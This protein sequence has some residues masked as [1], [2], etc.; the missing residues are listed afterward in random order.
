MSEQT[1]N[2]SMSGEQTLPS[3]VRRGSRYL[4]SGRELAAAL[5]EVAD[6]LDGLGVVRLCEVALM[7]SLQAVPWEDPADRY[8]TVTALASRFGTEPGARVD[9][10]GRWSHFGTARDTQMPGGAEVS[11]FT[12]YTPG[13]RTDGADVPAGEPD[14]A[15]VA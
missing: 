11:V 13:H 3:P 4:R 1:P 10:A 15:E 5:R 6:E 14:L 2:A 9:A 7:V 12:A 8:A